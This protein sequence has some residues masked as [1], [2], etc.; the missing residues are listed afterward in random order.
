MEN[1]NSTFP[2]KNKNTAMERVK[3]ARFL[4]FLTLNKNIRYVKGKF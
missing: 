3:M 2:T 4:T 1:A